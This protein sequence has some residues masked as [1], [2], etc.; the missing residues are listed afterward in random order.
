MRRA[1]DEQRK[2]GNR[3][4]HDDPSEQRRRP[5]LDQRGDD[6]ERHP[7]RRRIAQEDIEAGELLCRLAGEGRAILRESAA[8]DDRA[9]SPS[10]HA[11]RERHR[12]AEQRA[13]RAAPRAIEQHYSEQRK[14]EPDRL[15]AH[16]D[17]EP[18]D[19]RA[20]TINR[21][22]SAMAAGSACV[23]GSPPRQTPIARHACAASAM[24][25]PVMSLSGRS[26]VNQNS[27]EATTTR[28]ASA[29]RRSRSAASD[30]AVEHL[31]A[32]EQR[33]ERK[34]GQRTEDRAPEGQRAGIGR[35]DGMR[36]FAERDEDGIPGRVGL[37]IRRIEIA[38]AERE[39]HRVEIF[40][41]RRK[42]GQ[43]RDEKNRGKRGGPEKLRRDLQTWRRIRPSF[44]LPV[45]YP[46]G[47]MVTD[48]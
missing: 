18:R 38:H 13:G 27:G 36:Q 10:E 26:A 16:A 44:K 41:R 29:T 15:R 4:R 37:M 45:R 21:P 3:D 48:S 28:V 5:G 47:S 8:R 20:G 22:D 19:Q 7:P 46:F 9:G 2:P 23:S 30:A 34:H 31:D 24:A 1:P 39:V 40:E 12:A 6:P 25:R 42:K 32:P 43:M 35:P 11:D 14:R 17:G 33:D